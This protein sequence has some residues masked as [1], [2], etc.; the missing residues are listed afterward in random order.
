M[1]T[2]VQFTGYNFVIVGGDDTIS[3]S[4]ISSS[5]WGLKY[6]NDFNY[7]SNYVFARSD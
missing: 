6:K 4:S 7:K 3:F 2:T 1:D 5:S